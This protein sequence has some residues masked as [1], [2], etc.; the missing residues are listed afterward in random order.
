MRYG[1]DHREKTNKRITDLASRRFR[2][3][4]I[5]A[6][7]IAGLMADVG[8]THGGFYSHFKSKEDLVMQAL[9]NALKETLALLETYAEENNG[10][11]EALVKAYLHPIH[12]ETPEKGCAIA[13]VGPELSRLPKGSQ[14]VINDF[15]EQFLALIEHYLPRTDL[16]EK[17]HQAAVAIFALLVGSIQISR[18]MSGEKQKDEVLKSGIDAALALVKTLTPT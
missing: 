12:R 7:G 1:K 5:H 9:S 11:I 14:Q 2:K 6:V 13:A 4:G 18:M 10:G 16:S 17:R 8:L 3:E 15:I